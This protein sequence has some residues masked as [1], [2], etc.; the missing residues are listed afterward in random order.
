M[1][2]VLAVAIT[3]LLL[4]TGC[5]RPGLCS[6]TT[7]RT[8]VA[9]PKSM[10][11][12]EL[13]LYG[14]SRRYETLTRPALDCTG[15]PVMWQEPR[16]DECAE[17]GPRPEPLPASTV[18]PTEDDVTVRIAGTGLQIVWLRLQSFSNGEAEG[19]V[20][21]VSVDQDRL[22]V[23]A[24]GTLRSLPVTRLSLETVGRNRLLVAEGEFCTPGEPPACQSTTR[25]L[26][27]RNGRFVATPVV[28]REGRCLGPD[29]FPRHREQTYALPNG[30]LRKIEQTASLDL[31]DDRVVL[32]ESI[33]VRDV[34]PRQKGSLPEPFHTT[35]AK[36]T[37]MIQATN[38][39]SDAP[40]PWP[41]V[42]AKFAKEMEPLQD[43]ATRVAAQPEATRP[44][45]AQQQPSMTAPAA[46]SSA[47]KPPAPAPA[48]P[49][50][51]PAAPAS[52][53]SPASKAPA[54]AIANPAG[55][56]F[57]KAT[58]PV[59]RPVLPVKPLPRL[60]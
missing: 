17:P 12:S 7:L 25:L 24:V 45:Q 6:L 58:P 34:D 16:A 33:D 8:E 36:R 28:S 18:L 59:P 35:R 3:L 4:L 37:L 27:L 52:T 44:S 39:V 21:L 60:P 43:S 48:V 46:A 32:N 42:L 30:L 5:P 56:S 54:P 41:A 29:W 26:M 53:T 20:A 57:P 40:S 51:K 19:P 9:N 2:R 50:S 13:L 31:K 38:I 47:S 49:A 14:H 23:E 55:A 10:T 11:W 1:G 22:I 15:V